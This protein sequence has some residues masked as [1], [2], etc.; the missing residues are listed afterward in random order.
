MHPG[1][2]D[3][4][5]FRF[6]CLL[7]QTKAIADIIG[8]ILDIRLLVVMRQQDGVALPLQAQD[9]VLQVEES[10]RGGHTRRR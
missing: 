5:G 7:R 9:L 8:Y 1:K 10:S 3:H 6:L 4:I 2:H